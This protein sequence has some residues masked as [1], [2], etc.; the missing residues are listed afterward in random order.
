MAVDD[1]FVDVYDVWV[2]WVDFG[3]WDEFFGDVGDEAGVECVFFDEF[4]ED[5]LGDLVVFHVV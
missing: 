2:F 3:K 4:F 5:L 1:E